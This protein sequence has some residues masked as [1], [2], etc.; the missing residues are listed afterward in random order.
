MNAAPTATIALLPLILLLLVVVGL[1]YGIILWVRG[2]RSRGDGQMACGGCGYAVRGLESLNCP[3]CG[4]DLRKV[5]INR[6]TS[7]SSGI[8]IALTIICGGILLLGCLG[9]S[10]FLMAS[11]SSSSSSSIKLQAQPTP[12]T[13]TSL[14][15]PSGPNTANAPGLPESPDVQDTDTPEQDTPLDTTP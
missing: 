1:I 5:G 15:T 9:S 4:A 13:S 7:G 10:F 3:E 14:S 6:G 11:G 2:G 12:K 8:G